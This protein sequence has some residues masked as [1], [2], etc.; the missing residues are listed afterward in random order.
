MLNMNLKYFE[1][2]KKK[3]ILAWTTLTLYCWFQIYVQIPEKKVKFTRKEEDSDDSGQHIKGVF[4]IA[5]R[6]SVLLKGGQA[7]I[8]FEEEKGT[9]NRTSI[10]VA[11]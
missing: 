7:L 1:R 8:T 11:S 4:T 9:G 6:P 10:F 2:T 5:Q 3:A